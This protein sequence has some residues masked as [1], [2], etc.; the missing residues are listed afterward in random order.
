MK[1]SSKFVFFFCI[2]MALLIGRLQRTGNW[3]REGWWH[4]AKGPRPGIEPGATVART[5]RK[6]AL[7]NE[8]WMFRQSWNS[9]SKK[10][11][12]I[13]WLIDPP[14]YSRLKYLHKNTFC[15]KIHGDQRMNPIDTGD[16]LSSVLLPKCGWHLWFW[17]EMFRYQGIGIEVR[18]F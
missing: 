15:T 17:V 3:M 18:Y 1:G 9:G 10:V 5:H 11:T 4:T 8:C 13:H 6:P 12:S 14:L 2:C 7:P 16:Q